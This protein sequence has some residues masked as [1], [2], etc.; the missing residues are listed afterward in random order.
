MSFF[1]IEKLM[2]DRLVQELPE[3]VRVFS[4][5]DLASVPANAQVVPAV[6]VVYGGFEVTEVKNDRKSAKVR[7]TWYAVPVVRN[8]AN[9]IDGKGARSVSSELVDLTFDALAGWKPG[10]AYFPLE[11]VTP[12]A[13]LWKKGLFYIPLAFKATTTIG[14]APSH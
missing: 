1:D 8:V 3:T 14:G 13:P 11:P 2:I 4:A 5:A 12:P 10:S 6:H 9:Q 7:Q